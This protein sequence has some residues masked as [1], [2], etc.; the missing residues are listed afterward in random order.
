LHRIEIRDVYSIACVDRE[1]D[2]LA[3]CQRVKIGLAG[4][5]S[6]SLVNLG[7]FGY[8]DCGEH[9]NYHDNDHQL[10]KRECPRHL[11]PPAFIEARKVPMPSRVKL[12]VMVARDG[13]RFRADRSML[14]QG[15]HSCLKP[16]CIPI[17]RKWKSVDRI[18]K[19][20][21]DAARQLFSLP[22]VC[23]MTMIRLSGLSRA[24]SRISPLAALSLPTDTPPTF[25]TP[26][27]RS[28]PGA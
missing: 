12:S 6:C 13:S 27:D 7:E 17:P 10:D 3:Y 25:A 22:G 16:F 21:R 18:P 4:C 9:T 23:S 11:P 24:V 26:D 2:S 15:C 20:I 14:S 19:S 28:R 8:R 1:V 5:A